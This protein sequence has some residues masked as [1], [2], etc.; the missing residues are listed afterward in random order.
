MD[1]EGEPDEGEMECSSKKK[2]IIENRS[3][4]TKRDFLSSSTVVK[5]LGWIGWGAQTEGD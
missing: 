4:V 5:R 3:E 2:I 1:E